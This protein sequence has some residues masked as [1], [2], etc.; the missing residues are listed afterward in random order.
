VPSATIISS[1]SGGGKSHLACNLLFHGNEVFE[2][3][4]SRIIVVC[5]H[6][7]DIYKKL[8][9]KYECIFVESLEDCEQ[10]LKPYCVLLVD[11]FMNILD[12]PKASI[13]IT[14]FF[15]RRVHHEKINILLLL[16]CIFSKHL[17]TCFINCTYLF[18]G[19]WVKN[20]YSVQNFARQFK[21]TKSKEVLECYDEA[22]KDPYNFLLFDFHVLTPDNYR[23]RSGVFPPETVKIYTV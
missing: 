20:L 22:T 6:M 7:Q 17:R 23:L 15:T 14:E 19:R 12:T 1:P 13:Y 2:K 16:Q 3:P 11:D 8:E 4:I 18:L 5:K 9:E 10:F 21:P